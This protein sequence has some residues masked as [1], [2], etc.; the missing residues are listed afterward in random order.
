MVH[1]PAVH[2]HLDE[3]VPHALVQPPVLGLAL[4]QG[5]LGGAF[6]RLVPED[7]HHPRDVPLL[8]ENGGAAV[9]NGSPGPILGEEQCVVGQS[10]HLAFPQDA[11]HWIL[12]RLLGILPD[13]LEH[14]LEGSADRL[15]L[16]PAGKLLRH[17]VHVHH[18]PSDIRG[19][20][21]IP[22]AVEGGPD[23]HRALPHPGFG[24]LA[25]GIDPVQDARGPPGQSHQ[26]CGED[27]HHQ[28]GPQRPFKG[29]QALAQH[30][31]IAEEDWNPQQEREYPS[32]QNPGRRSTGDQADGTHVRAE[33]QPP[34]PQEDEGHG[35][36]QGH[37]R[38]V[39]KT[40]QP[41]RTVE[42]A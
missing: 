36:V 18:A 16:L 21:P 3:G 7:Q 41:G 17:G 4:Q 29:A 27:D 32:Q 8:I 31:D 19:E 28:G 37:L 6:G 20:H 14:L 1:D 25:E 33:Q 23:L 38:V 22:D 39:A 11:G 5:A 42:I 12:D 34:Q 30:P 10:D 15:G 35:R 2:I 13:D 40:E 26:S 24:L 9:G